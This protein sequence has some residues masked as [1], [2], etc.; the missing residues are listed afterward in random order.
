MGGFLVDQVCEPVMT[1][2]SAGGLFSVLFGRGKGSGAA[3]VMFIL[4]VTGTAICLGFGR[5]L[6]K[7][8]YTDKP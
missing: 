8:E 7:Y 6:K 5:I 3:M 4:G 2:A 1:S